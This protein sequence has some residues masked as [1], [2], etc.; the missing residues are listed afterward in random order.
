M[1]MDPD[2]ITIKAMIDLGVERNVLWGSDYHAIRLPPI[3][4]WCRRSRARWRSCRR[5]PVTTSLTQ[6]ALRFYRLPT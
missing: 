2:E 5:A 6:N 1:S 4:A 3:L